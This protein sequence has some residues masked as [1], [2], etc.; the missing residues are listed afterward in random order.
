L[1]EEV[2]VSVSLT[3]GHLFSYLVICEKANPSV[4]MTPSNEEHRVATVIEK[5][6]RIVKKMKKIY[7]RNIPPANMKAASD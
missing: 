7:V 2:T 4:K 6:S 1:K 5:C 3:L